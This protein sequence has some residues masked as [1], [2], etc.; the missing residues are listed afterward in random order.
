M[1]DIPNFSIFDDYLCVLVQSA[2]LLGFTVIGWY[3]GKFI[4]RF[5]TRSILCV[6]I[7]LKQRMC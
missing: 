7:K 2:F 6:Y 1:D 5:I 3:T 4:I